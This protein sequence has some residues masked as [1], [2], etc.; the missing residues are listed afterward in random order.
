[1]KFRI[2]IASAA[3]L[4]LAACGNTEDASVEAEADTVEIPADDALTDVDAEAVED[5][6]ATAADTEA[7]EG[8]EAAEAASIEEAGD[9]AAATAE[10][11]MEA[12]GD[13]LEN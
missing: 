2:A 4:V 13:D 10:A 6:D 9:E 7:G 3:A 12:M 5:A 8:R 11:A 1:M